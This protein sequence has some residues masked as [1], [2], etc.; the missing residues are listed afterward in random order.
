[1]KTQP[2][3]LFVAMLLP[4]SAVAQIPD[5]KESGAVQVKAGVDKAGSP[6][7]AWRD[8]IENRSQSSIEAV[9]AVFYCPGTEKFKLGGWT[10]SWDYLLNF[11]IDKEV[12]P[13]GSFELDS[14]DP[15]ECPGQVDAV[16]FSDGHVEGDPEVLDDLYI[17][18]RGVYEMLG[19]IIPHVDAIAKQKETPQSVIDFMDG[20]V[21]ANSFNLDLDKTER[22]GM[23]LPIG[24][25]KGVLKSQT[26][27]GGP[28][29]FKA[30]S[31]PLNPSP[32]P[33]ENL[34]HQQLM[35]IDFSR[36]LV[37]WRALLANNLGTQSNVN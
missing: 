7:T 13:G 31:Q 8:V 14:V 21:K 23:Y 24:L 36:Q 10:I 34:S 33:D 32:T 26:P 12:P 3:F 29:V 1:L 11:G 18:R 17:Q 20:R 22:M 6:T 30:D 19:E 35:A 27:W 28:T 25:A 37:R 9:E 4:L 5:L 16:I 15:S 2:L